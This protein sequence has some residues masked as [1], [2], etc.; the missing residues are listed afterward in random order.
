MN[1][2]PEG[3]IFKT[4]EN[5]RLISSTEGLAEAMERGIILEAPYATAI[6]ILSLICHAQTGS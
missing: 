6:T 2:K 1:Y 4:A 3:S 5:Q